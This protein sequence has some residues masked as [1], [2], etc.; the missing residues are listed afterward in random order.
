MPPEERRWYHDPK[1]FLTLIA[2]AGAIWAG[3]SFISRVASAPDT[4]DAVQSRVEAV[5]DWVQQE[6]AEAW[7]QH[8][9]VHPEEMRRLD[10]KLEE[11]DR[12]SSYLVCDRQRRRAELD[13]RPFTRDCEA[14]LLAP[15]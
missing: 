3:F 9:E 14:E 1:Q 2:L 4:L 7:P 8:M 11:L 13:S 15:R 12:T 6:E 5:E 10:S